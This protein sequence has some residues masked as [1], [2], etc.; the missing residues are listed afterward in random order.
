MAVR[1][2]FQSNLKIT[3]KLKRLLAEAHAKE[4]SEDDLREQRVSFAFGNAPA[5]SN[6]ITK[7][8]V[9]L[10]SRRIRLRRD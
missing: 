2:Q 3:P 10:A 1:K 4:V 5:D 7:D 8:S 9:E 6:L